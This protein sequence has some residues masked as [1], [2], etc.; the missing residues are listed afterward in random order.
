MLSKKHR[1]NRILGA[2]VRLARA[3][4]VIAAAEAATAKRD[5]IQ[6]EIDWLKNAPVKDGAAGQELPTAE[7]IASHV[8]VRLDRSK[9]DDGAPAVEEIQPVI[10]VAVETDDTSPRFQSYVQ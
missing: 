9:K 10:D 2:S 3:Q 5:E 8:A 1:N 7:E 6:R 4:N